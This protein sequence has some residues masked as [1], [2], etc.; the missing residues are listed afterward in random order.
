MPDVRRGT[1]V[2]AMMEISATWRPGTKLYCVG[3]G[4]HLF[5]YT[6]GNLVA[7]ACQCG[8]YAPIAVPDLESPEGMTPTIPASLVR[9]GRDLLLG[10][11][12][13]PPAHLEYYLGFSPFTCPA[14]VQWERVLRQAGAISM[15]DCPEERCQREWLRWKG[16]PEEQM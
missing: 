8:A 7:L 1:V 14:K 2:S 10:R 9:L 3:C 6:P 5:N 12:V 16:P 11:Q 15:G 4:R 13:R